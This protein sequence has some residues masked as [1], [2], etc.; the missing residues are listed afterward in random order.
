VIFHFLTTMESGT[1][2]MGCRCLIN[3]VTSFP[4]DIYPVIEILGYIVVLCFK[5][6]RNSVLFSI[7]V[8]LIFIPTSCVQDSLFTTFSPVVGI[9]CLFDK[10]HSYCSEMISHCGF[11]LH[12]S[13]D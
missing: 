5:F 9:F 13:D 10:S 7:K 6:Y 12:F 1:I 11:D 2:K 3:I 8:V 4:L